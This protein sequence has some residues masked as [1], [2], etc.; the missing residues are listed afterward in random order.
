[1]P[2]PYDY[3]LSRLEQIRDERMTHANTATRVGEAM[4]MLLRYLTGM[5]A[6]FLRKDCED[7]SS[8]LLHLLAGA[9]V[10][11][12]DDIRL[13][14]DGS[15]SCGR[16]FVDGS[17]VFRELVF[18]HQ[19]VLEGDT[20]FTDRGIIDAVE[21]APNGEIRLVLRKMHDNDRLTFHVNDVLRCAMNNLDTARTYRTS[22]MRVNS[23]DL[24]T[25]SI[26]V[27][28][29]DDEDVPGGQ[30]YAPAPSA[31]MI[32]WG[33]TLDPDR[34]SVFFIS[35]EDGRFLF[36]QG[37]TQPKIDQTNYSAFIGLPPQLDILDG[38][39]INRRHPYIYARGLI[40]QDIIRLDYQGYPV[41]TSRDCGMWDPTRQYIHGYDSQREGYF[42][43]HVWHG[44][45][46]WRASV[47][48]P[49]VGREPRYNNTDWTCL[50]GGSNMDIEISSSAGDWFRAG[51]HWQTTLSVAVY[52][53]EMLLTE[54]EIGMAHITWTRISSDT[55]GD[56]VWNALHPT[57]SCGLSLD[58]DSDT[59]APS[60]WSVGSSVAF[61]CEVYIPEIGRRTVEYSIEL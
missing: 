34:Q 48:L 35:S 7:S 47:S 26:T 12:S 1:M 59:D 39:P 46:Y 19:N 22:W 31:R 42:T 18:N 30:N 9:V 13:N 41:Y 49:T 17:A 38:L 54:E 3:T 5:D 36:L 32:R 58:I 61:R 55:G 51:T 14:P 57:G 15:I 20:Y 45:C 50:L 16:L 60:P 56:T 43:D 25:N 53:A 10:G 11:E 29:Y 37:L 27:V 40:V 52:N 2:T 33:N 28:L 4:I 44:G 24:N 8:Y 6:P 23:V 21:Y